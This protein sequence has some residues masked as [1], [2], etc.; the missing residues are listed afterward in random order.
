[1]HK[2]IILA[3]GKGSRLYPM[4]LAVCKQL[5][6]IYDKP[7]VFYPFSVLLM[8]GIRDI[9]LISTPEDLPRFQKLLGDGSDWGIR[10]RYQQQIEP[11]GLAHA[12]IIG[13]EFIGDESC[14]LVLGDNIFYGDSLGQLLT[15]AQRNEEGATI[16]A[17][18]VSNP[19]DYGVVDF[20]QD[21]RAIHLEEKPRF[22]R[23][24]F[25]V[26]GLYFYDNKV[27]EV[28]KNLKPSKRHELEITD[29]N[30]WYLRRG[31]LHVKKMGRGMAWL[32]TGTVDS[33]LEA[34]CFIETVEK[35]QGLKVCCPWEIAFRMG[36]IDAAKVREIADGMHNN[37]YGTYLRNLV[38]ESNPKKT[39][40]PAS[41]KD[42]R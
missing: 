30:D 26:T 13:E 19:E 1:M 42:S 15:Q 12:F 16:F 24:H 10:I 5:L 8:A 18:P 9:L 22:P 41:I 35:R 25:A 3:G 34:S 39:S 32:D 38:H 28:A 29:V 31:L 40:Q 36:F 21:G 4:T 7:M 33:L 14:A 6:P 17:Y 20:N 37:A 23:S 27:I 2:G 11:L